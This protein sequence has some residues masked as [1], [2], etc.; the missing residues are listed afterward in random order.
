MD[1]FFGKL[2]WFGPKEITEN[3]IF[4]LVF[5][6]IITFILC[7]LIYVAIKKQKIDKAPSTSVIMVEGLITMGDNYASDL[8]DHRLDKAHYFTFWFSSHWKQF[9]CCICSDRC[10]MIY[11]NRDRI[12]IPKN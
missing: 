5:L 2:N 12:C 7:I 8:S 9:K 3:H 10:N 1:R 4:S 6:V 11:N